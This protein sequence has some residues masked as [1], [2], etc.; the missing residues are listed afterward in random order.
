[1]IENGNWSFDDSQSI[2][3]YKDHYEAQ[4]IAIDLVGHDDIGDLYTLFRKYYGD[5][6]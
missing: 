6:Y 1:M 4:P 2:L 3:Y 5:M